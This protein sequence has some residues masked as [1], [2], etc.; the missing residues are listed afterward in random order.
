MSGQ[1]S[2]SRP[3][4]WV[5]PVCSKMDACIRSFW[6]GHSSNG[7][8]KLKDFNAALLSKWGWKLVTNEESFCFSILKAHYLRHFDFFDDIPKIRDSCFWKSILA[9][10]S[11]IK[12]GACL[13]MGDGAS[14]DPWKDPWQA[15]A[16]NI[17]Q[18]VLPIRPRPDKWVWTPATN[19]KYSTKSA[20]LTAN[21]QRFSS[22]DIP[23]TV[24][25]R[26]WGHKSIL[27]RHKMLW[28]QLL[29]N[30]LPTRDKLNSLFHID[31]ILCY[32]CRNSNETGAHLLFS[33]DFSRHFWLAS[34]WNLRT[35]LLADL[36]PLEGFR[37]IWDMDQNKPGWIKINL[38]AAIREDNAAIACVVRD[39]GGSIVKWATIKI[40][41]SSPLVAALFAVEL[42]VIARWPS[43]LFTSDSKMVINALN[44]L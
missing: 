38:D 9:T 32:I 20:Y 35:E 12:E 25:L 29:S 4:T 24:W 16:I 5:Q 36:S 27:P 2:P 3:T 28:W 15:D 23:R 26:L 8:Q 41:T 42:A 11:L 13:I 14:I 33:C 40:S 22:L 30:T 1:G 39:A 31:D 18:I 43:M 7:F 19:G 10:K 17:A 37:F 6:W 44:A 21:K 34:P